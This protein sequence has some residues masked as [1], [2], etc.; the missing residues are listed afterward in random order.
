VL[1]GAWQSTY[2]EIESAMAEQIKSDAARRGLASRLVMVDKTF[3]IEK[4][5][6]AADLF[7]LPTTREGLPNVLLEAMASAVP[8]VI[9]H[10]PGVTD[11]IVQDGVSGR[12]L[13][14]ADQDGLVT[15]MRTLLGDDERRA[16]MARAARRVVE[17][18]FSTQT[19]AD[20]TMTVYRELTGQAA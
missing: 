14:A 9:T 8:P 16:A 15:A 6:R 13:D 3:A 12:L 1:V 10:L 17:E 19:T 20:A 4:Y 2:Y 5:Y 11:W 7:V 18:Q